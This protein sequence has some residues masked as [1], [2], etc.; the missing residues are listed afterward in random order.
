MSPTIASTLRGKGITLAIAIVRLDDYRYSSLPSSFLADLDKG[1]QAARLNGIKV[2]LRFAYN[3]SKTADASQ[4]R[5]L[6]HITQLKPILQKNADV[7]AVMQAGFI[8]A[9]GEWHSS[10]NGLDN[11]TARTAIMKALLDALPTSRNIQVRTPMFKASSFGSASLSS[12]EAFNGSARARIGHHNDCFLSSSSDMGTFA[13]PV[14]DWKTY[15]GNDG[16]FTPIGGETCAV[17]TYSTCSNAVAQMKAQHFSYL[18]KDYKPEV[19]SGFDAGG[20]ASSIRRRIG[21]RFTTTRVSH[22]KSVAPGGELEVE[23]DIFN[24]GYA[25]PFNRRPAYIVLTGNGITYK[26]RLSAAVDVRK[27]TSQGTT[28]VKTKLRIPSALASGT[29][30][31][32]LWMPDHTDTLRSDSRYAIRLANPTGWDDATGFNILSTALTISSSAPGPKVSGAT[33]FAEIL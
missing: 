6:G 17:S 24:G 1:F 16:R 18:N 10:T 29:Y 13:S 5:I 23:L 4:S 14:T 3:A 32:A 26:A 27:W 20:C 28:T 33:T 11:T 8:G 2:I 15:V 30:K 25:T 7:I 31:I 22:S 9:W 19:I 21:Y 12:T